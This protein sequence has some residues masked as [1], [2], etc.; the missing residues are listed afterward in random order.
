MTC[1]AVLRAFGFRVYAVAPSRKHQENARAAGLTYV[2]ESLEALGAARQSCGALMEG[3]G[4]ENTLRDAIPYLRRG[5]EVFQIGVPWQ[6]KS[7]WDAHDLL[8]QLFY[9]FIS[10]HGG[11]EW[12]IPLK[13]DE[14][15]VHSSYGH[16]RTAMEMIAD[17]AITIPDTMY[18]LRNPAECEQVYT[19]L[20]ES[21]LGAVSVI[22]D[23]RQF[24]E[25]Q[26]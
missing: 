10:I 4:H 18:E 17:G 2:G 23:W 1:A 15:H 9:A 3:S 14:F 22:L 6:K 12:S 11:W 26:A 13:D 16:I 8:Y 7:D 5:A 19:E 21:S 24:K 20:A 25:E